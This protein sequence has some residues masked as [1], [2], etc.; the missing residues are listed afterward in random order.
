MAPYLFG[1][2]AAEGSPSHYRS[3]PDEAKKGTGN[4]LKPGFNEIQQEDS[5]RLNFR[6]HYEAR[7]QIQIALRKN[8]TR[9]ESRAFNIVQ[10]TCMYSEQITPQHATLHWL[11]DVRLLSAHRTLRAQEGSSCT[12]PAVPP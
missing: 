4:L 8:Q 6:V 12:L 7:R 5:P 2:H 1:R 9:P 3:F 10:R 11:F